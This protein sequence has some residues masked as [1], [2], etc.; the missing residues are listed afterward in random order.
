MRL[1]LGSFPVESLSL[2]SATQLQGRH[3]MVSADEL[4]AAVAHPA[5]AGLELAI[6]HPG[7][8]A[9][10]TQLS[11]VVE[12]RI[13]VS[14]GGDVFPGLVGPLES[15]GGGRPHRPARVARRV[16]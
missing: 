5:I 10:I 13:K 8:S 11:D 6:V 3:L 1:E 4:R 12:P 15:V 14:G 7:E 9:R 2:G 16:P